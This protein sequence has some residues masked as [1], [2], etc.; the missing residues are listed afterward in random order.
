MKWTSGAT[1]GKSD[2]KQWLWFEFIL[3]SHRLIRVV[4][5]F[6]IFTFA[7]STW[8]VADQE[9]RVGIV[10]LHGKTSEPNVVA[11]GVVA[12]LDQAGFLVET[13]EMPWSQKRYIDKSFEDAL[14]E[15]DQA[16]ARLVSRGATKVVI[17]GHS[18]GA[19]AALA[20]A[21][22]RGKVAGIIL[23]A[24]GAVP[25]SPSFRRLAPDV[26]KAKAMIDAGNGDQ[27]STFGD[28]NMGKYFTRTMKASVY[29]SYFR[30]DG[31]GAAAT[32]ASNISPDIP[33]LYVA[34]SADPLT[35]RLGK[36]FIFDKLPPNPLS[37]YVV[38]KAGHLG[39]PAAA[40]QEIIAWL[41]TLP[42]Q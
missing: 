26:A 16:V 31:I 5:L 8:L 7:A 30:P 40:V 25:D 1:T 29:Y 36:S 23:L 20:Y 35:R 14:D 37:K 12:P 13:P 42:T 9:A 27:E 24:P 39:T 41:H 6:A 22:H 3:D 21:A 38:V 11:E 17:A 32:N 18:M 2:C 33:V 28:I 10:L 4:G 19:D 34:G 15:I